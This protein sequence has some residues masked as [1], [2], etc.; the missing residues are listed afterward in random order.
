[1][2]Q[3]ATVQTSTPDNIKLIETLKS[4]HNTL[5]EYIDACEN[6]GRKIILMMLE[7]H[8]TNKGIEVSD[9]CLNDDKYGHWDVSAVVNGYL[10]VFEVKTR[11]CKHNTYSDCVLDVK[12]VHRVINH[13][14]SEFT[15]NKD[16]Y[17]KPLKGAIG[18]FVASYQDK[19]RVWNLSASLSNFNKRHYTGYE[20]SKGAYTS[21]MV[22]G[23]PN[24]S[25]KVFDIDGLI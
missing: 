5:Q 7:Q 18:A 23:L 12:K 11:N 6:K 21:D 15:N 20:G 8:Y 16:K 14:I 4:Q 24:S 10:V 19:L 17:S 1:M 2:E 25:S 22:Y 3:N 9:I 13:A